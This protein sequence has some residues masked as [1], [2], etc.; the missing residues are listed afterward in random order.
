MAGEEANEK[1]LGGVMV[2]LRAL[3]PISLLYLGNLCLLSF[4]D[5]F[6]SEYQE[7]GD[8]GS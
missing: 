1:P 2:K 7:M 3:W 4:E 8:C 5:G 6:E